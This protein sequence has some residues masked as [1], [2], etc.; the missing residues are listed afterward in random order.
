MWTRP[1][2][3]HV[4]YITCLGDVIIIIIPSNKQLL[5]GVEL[6]LLTCNMDTLAWLSDWRLKLDK[7]NP[8]YASVLSL[9]L[10]VIAAQVLIKVVTC[11]EHNPWARVQVVK[12]FCFIIYLFTHMFSFSKHNP[13]IIFY[14]RIIIDSYHE[15]MT[16]RS[17][18][19]T[20]CQVSSWQKKTVPQNRMRC[21]AHV[22]LKRNIS[23]RLLV[24]NFKS[25]QD[26]KYH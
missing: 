4:V 2:R 8:C 18:T 9:I 19:I 10:V 7:S 3:I 6:S 21:H 17:D 24:S 16:I 12:C 26:L 20:Y 11:Q 23:A 13:C 25:T 5:M 22:K 1:R 15:G 14:T